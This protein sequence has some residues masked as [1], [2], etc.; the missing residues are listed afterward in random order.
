MSE[1]AIGNGQLVSSVRSGAAPIASAYEV[2]MM[3]EKLAVL[4]DVIISL[5]IQLVFRATI[6]LRRWNY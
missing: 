3:R 1:I 5:G 4:R 2:A 6:L